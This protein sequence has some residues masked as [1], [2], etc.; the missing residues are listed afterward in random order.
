MKYLNSLNKDWGTS[1]LLDGVLAW[2]GASGITLDS[3]DSKKFLVLSL[4]SSV[5]DAFWNNTHNTNL[6]ALA[7]LDFILNTQQRMIGQ[8]QKVRG[9]LSEIVY[10]EMRENF[11]WFCR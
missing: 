3:E 11:L 2:S 1:F 9:S 4:D 5:Q 7:A 10:N 6:L 8:D